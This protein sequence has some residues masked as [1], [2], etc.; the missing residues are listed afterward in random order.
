[1]LIHSS[2]MLC[3]RCPETE[4]TDEGCC[5]R[6]WDK[7]VQSWAWKVVTAFQQVVCGCLCLVTEG[8]SGLF[9]GGRV[10]PVHFHSSDHQELK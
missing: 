1:M 5:A 8:E 7:A 9:P 3:R 10:L 6:S 2:T 4:M